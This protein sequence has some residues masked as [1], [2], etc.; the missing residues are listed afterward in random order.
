MYAKILNAMRHLR[1]NRLM[2]IFS[3]APV[4]LSVALMNIPLFSDFDYEFN[5]ALG[6]T[7][8]VASVLIGSLSVKHN[9]SPHQEPSEHNVIEIPKSNIYIFL[10]SQ[11]L[12]F[13][14]L[15]FSLFVVA[16]FFLF[17]ETC[18]FSRGLQFFI[19]LPVTSSVIGNALGYMLAVVFRKLV[20][21]TVPVVLIL[22]LA[23]N[24]FWLKWN[25]PIYVYSV[26]WGYFPGP[27]YDEWIP[28][29][30]TI[31]FHRLW[32]L[33]FALLFVVLAEMWEQRPFFLRRWI[34]YLT[35][36]LISIWGVFSFRNRIGFDT[37]YE[38]IKT[39]LSTVLR[40]SNV[41]VFCYPELNYEDAKW[42][43]A[44][45]EFYYDRIRQFLDLKSDRP[46][47]IYVYKDEYQKKQLMG[48]GRTNFAK[49]VNDEIHVNYE[50]MDGVL[51]HEMTHVLANE[52]GN[53]VYSTTKIGFLEGLAVAS[54]WNE[55]FFTPH[56]WAAALKK[57]NQL[58]DIL[59]LI[60]GSGFFK[61]ASGMSYIVSGSFTKFLIDSFGVD[62]FKKAY[63]AKSVEKVYSKGP[64]AL[65]DQWLQFLD[66]LPIREDDIR[67]AGL[68][69][70]PSLF[71]KKCPHYIADL[72]EKANQ[73]YANGNYAAAAESFQM[74]LRTDNYNYRIRMSWIRCQY[75]GG[76]LNAASRAVDSLLADKRP[77]Y[78]LH[79]S[80][81]LLKGDIYLRLAKEDSAAMEY[82]NVCDN[83][84]NILYIYNSAK[85][86]ADLLNKGQF[87]SLSKLVGTPNTTEQEDLLTGMLEKDP[88]NFSAKLWLARL[89]FQRSD[90]PAVTALLSES[91]SPDSS[92]N[93]E[94]WNL[95]ADS[96]LRLAQYD[97]AKKCIMEAQ[98]ITLRTMER[99]FMEQKLI[100]V[101]WLESRF[102]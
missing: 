35:F 10:Y 21:V 58:P 3:V 26:F 1:V 40:S 82:V 102:N 45:S 74:A 54:E 27:L 46:I 90:F 47:A 43:L 99:E 71:Q 69:I 49:T 86:R 94:K 100:L 4:V 31:L 95:L 64:E 23:L 22:N 48:A 89:F 62:L 55:N 75:Y 72:L 11:I 78:V 42:I 44:L 30:S 51:K 16:L 73:A 53:P 59:P 18:S 37:T 88:Y 77:N 76:D 25:V 33:G 20:W 52:F 83:Y 81:Q 7:V 8:F 98:K 17:C 41:T 66:R 87:A 85:L 96:H 97:R 70:Q 57:Q 12:I 19:L 24:V 29:T 67:L 60:G 9:Y 63:Y 28:V 15:L 56:E 80:M 6:M 36:I 13:L 2:V 79:A 93:F 92:L 32:S 5:Q 39:S 101:Q 65:A 34:L 91:D 50:D 38:D 84:K 14:S 61:N 68:L